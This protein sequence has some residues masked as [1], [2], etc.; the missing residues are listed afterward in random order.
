V[1]EQRDVVAI[2]AGGGT[3]GHLYPALSLAEALVELR[4]DVRPFFVGAARGLEARVLPERGVEH[5]LLPVRGITRGGG[6]NWAVLP[7]LVRSLGQVRRL[8]RRLRPELVVVTGGYAGAPAGIVA[9]LRRVPL[10][11][12]EQNSL[13]GL[14][15]RLLARWARQVHLAFPEAAERLP[16]VARSRV[17]TSGN[18][19]R[20]EGPVDREAARRLFEL[21]RD[22]Q[23]VLMVG[24]SQGSEALNRLTIDAVRMVEAGHLHRPREL[25]LIWAT[26]RG[27]LERVRDALGG[28]VPSWIRLR[29]YIDEMPAALAAADVAISRAGAMTTSE[30]LVWGLPMVLVP[31]PT[32]AAD[33]QTQ[34]AK[35][36]EAAGA[37][38][39]L[40]EEGL[41]GQE[42][43]EAVEGLLAD[44]V[45]LHA[46]RKAALAR[47]RPDAAR[48]IAT[49]LSTLLPSPE[50]ER[51]TAE[52]HS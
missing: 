32:A 29:G 26:G 15:T 31:L 11:L 33:H 24:G 37:A 7:A 17:Q 25:S 48:Q 47:G 34:N 3:G 50:P 36:L 13:P 35:A 12:Q 23:V 28:S 30:F 2:F 42:L 49:A 41:S 6:G 39:C 44:P 45:R 21:P 5:L 52:V 16:E 9:V 14:T 19:V 38:T 18:P 8:F 43:W 4:P 27:H 51:S 22:G 10:V 1:H 40:L 20:C 46:Q